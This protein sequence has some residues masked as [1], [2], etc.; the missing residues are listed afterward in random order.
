MCYTNEQNRGNISGVLNMAEVLYMAD[1]GN[2]GDR[3]ERYGRIASMRKLSDL[4]RDIFASGIPGYPRISTLQW[5]ERFGKGKLSNNVIQ[6]WINQKRIPSLEFLVL[7]GILLRE[8]GADIGI[9]DPLLAAGD[10]IYQKLME[11]LKGEVKDAPL[12]DYSDLGTPEDAPMALPVDHSVR[13][14]QQQSYADRLAAMPKLLEAI[15]RDL[16]YRQMDSEFEV[17]QALVKEARGSH[18]NDSARFAKY[19]VVPKEW[20]DLIVEGRLEEAQAMTDTPMVLKLADKVPD[21]D[22]QRSHAELFSCLLPS[23][24]IKAFKAAIKRRQKSRG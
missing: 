20:V 15:T 14:Y 24:E 9:F 3:K 5:A 7:F 19:A 22:G 8:A 16:K 11:D 17:V 23:S 12:G 10:G 21:L 1:L 4:I 18:G 13:T 2:G 6:D